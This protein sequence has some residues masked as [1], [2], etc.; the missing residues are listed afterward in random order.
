MLPG[1]HE[2]ERWRRR[3]VMDHRSG[4]LALPGTTWRDWPAID[5]GDG[6]VLAGDMVA[7]TG[8]LGEVSWASAIQASRLAFEATAGSRTQLG[9]VA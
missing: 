2:R 4:A 9:T 7:A 5:R 8:P 1:W 3:Q 6:V